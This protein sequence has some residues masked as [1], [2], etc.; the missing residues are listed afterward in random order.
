MSLKNHLPARR[1][2]AYVSTLGT[3]QLHLRNPWVIAFWSAMF[4]GLGHLLLSKYLRGF[5]LFVWEVLIN[6]KGHINLAI[7]YSFLGNFEM[8]K[9]SL[10]TKWMLIYIPT[11]FF[12]IWD[13][14]RSTV[15]LNNM[16]QLAVREEAV[17]KPFK[18][19][20]LC[21][22]YLDK[23]PPW[24]SALWSFIAPGTGQLTINRIITA[25]YI[26]T[27][28]VVIVYY[29]NLLPAVH[30]T[31]AGNF[32]QGKA[33]L[34]VQ[35][36]LNIPSLYFFA[37]Y[38]A[39]V[40]T[41]ESNKLFDWEQ[42]KFLRDHYQSRFFNMPSRINN[43]SGS[44]YVVST[45]RHSITLEKAITAAEMQGIAK[46]NILAVSL[47]KRGEKPR[48]FD[49][50]QQSDGLSILDLPFILG[51]FLALMGAIYGFNF[52]WGP[53]L[54]GLIGFG[55]GFIIGLA[56]KLVFNQKSSSTRS[57]GSDPE[58]VLIIEC[59]ENEAEMVKDL[60]WNHEALGVRK[61]NLHT[62]Q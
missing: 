55:A 34:N 51:S 49:S 33:M 59:K 32:E 56:I 45:F 62:E 3:T 44:M 36:F 22:N 20:S 21:I 28:S 10:D 25:F 42:S 54:S 14:Y 15:D 19:D 39:Y 1:Y 5:L 7:Y 53:L 4:P 38:D 18:M 60:L 16:Y 24:S 17:V 27:W 31:W 48:L 35:W 37:A 61:L 6:L 12:A 40:N 43:G 57:A 58:V 8:A 26:L 50:M 52:R 2:V 23:K 47:D 13:S 29:S 9:Y 41:V 11:Y 46:D 30:Q